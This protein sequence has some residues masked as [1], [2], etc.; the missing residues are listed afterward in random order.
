MEKVSVVVPMYNVERY[1]ERCIASLLSQTYPLI[2]IIAISDASP[3]RSV[4][5]A[6]IMAA[7][8]KSGGGKTLI[9]K[10]L[11]ENIGVGKVRDIGIE[12]ATGKYM[13]FVDS[14]D[15]LSSNF[16]S[17]QREERAPMATTLCW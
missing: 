9:V 12:M 1:V 11:K 14:D 2:E 13:M 16:S 8:N 10:E 15:F 4:A 6:D 17:W 5:I 7:K 3:D